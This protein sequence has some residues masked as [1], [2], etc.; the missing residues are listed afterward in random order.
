MCRIA[1]PWCVVQL[2]SNEDAQNLR[3]YGCAWRGQFGAF[4]GFRLRDA[5]W[6]AEWMREC[7][8]KDGLRADG[9]EADG[10]T[11]LHGVEF[12]QKLLRDFASAAT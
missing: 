9:D 1:L 6:A 2:E 4:A 5:A 10:E 12:G 8:D 11:R 7:R 3:S